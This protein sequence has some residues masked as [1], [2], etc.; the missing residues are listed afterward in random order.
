MKGADLVS[1]S[2]LVAISGPI[3]WWLWSGNR[4]FGWFSVSLIGANAIVAGIKRIF[5]S[6]GFFGRPA[7]ASGCDLLCMAGA[8][9]REPGFPSGHMTTIA[10]AVSGIWYHTGSPV[11]LWIGIPWI[12]AMGWARWAKSCHNWQQITAG[13]LFGWA[14]GWFIGDYGA[15]LIGA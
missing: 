1:I 4:W 13:T 9:G 2:I 12:C 7:A 10:M 15:H 3:A 11:V 6:L 8:V 14:C 5:G